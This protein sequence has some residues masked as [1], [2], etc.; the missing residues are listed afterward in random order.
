MLKTIQL[1]SAIVVVIIT[2][3]FFVTGKNHNFNPDAFGEQVLGKIIEKSYDSNENVVL[4]LETKFGKFRLTTRYLPW[5]HD[6]ENLNIGSRIFFNLDGTKVKFLQNDE[7]LFL[8]KSKSSS[9]ERYLM[10]NGFIG[11]GQVREVFVLRS[12][13][14]NSVKLELSWKKEFIKR[15]KELTPSKVENLSLLLATLLGEK[16]EI[17]ENIKLLFRETSTAHLL[18]ISGLHVCLVFYAFYKLAKFIFSQSI[19]IINRYTALIPAL[20]VAELA[21][22]GYIMLC[23]W[24]IPSLRAFIAISIFVCGE[25]SIFPVSRVNALLCAILIILIIF[26]LSIFDISFQLSFSAV[27]G[28]YVAMQ[29]GTGDSS[30]KLIEKLNKNNEGKKRW[31]MRQFYENCLLA[32]KISFFSWLFTLPICL[33]WFESFIPLGPVI[34]F[35]FITL[36]VSVVMYTGGITLI[37][38]Y[39][40]LCL[41][42]LFGIPLWSGLLNFTLLLVDY[43]IQYLEFLRELTEIFGLGYHKLEGNILIIMFVLSVV[44]CG[45]LTIV[46]ITKSNMIFYRI[47]L[48]MRR[49]NFLQIYRG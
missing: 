24:S 3:M 1:I 8:Y 25:V 28:I 31:D 5:Q 42:N 33:Y 41:N 9:F 13:G 43:L 4:I 34:N 6:S 26:P 23:G 30:D 27:L 48:L 36:F 45:I 16:S 49:S 17:N 38:F 18:V 10:R 39:L 7:N 20:F 35:L 29:I 37:L 22:F 44:L 11:Y 2:Q 19:M 40:S 46:C 14:Y 32:F 12:E 47:R 21:T 15:L